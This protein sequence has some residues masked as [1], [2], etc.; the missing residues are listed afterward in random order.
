MR[1]K[2]VLGLMRPSSTTSM[3]TG[4]F[5]VTA[6]GKDEIRLPIHYLSL[7]SLH[8]MVLAGST[9]QQHSL[10]VALRSGAFTVRGKP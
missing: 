9:V 6:V 8:H 5:G 4:S 10:V 7:G 1:K 2:K 3:H